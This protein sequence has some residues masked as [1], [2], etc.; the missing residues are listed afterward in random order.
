MADLCTALMQQ[1]FDIAQR[2]RVADVQHPRQADDLRAGLEVTE[3]GALGH[4]ER[5]RDAAAHLKP[6]PSDGA[7]QKHTL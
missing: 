1:V 5:L 4:P 2:Q 7:S 6:R 3:R